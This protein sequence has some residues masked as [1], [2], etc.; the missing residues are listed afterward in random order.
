MILIVVDLVNGIMEFEG[1]FINSRG[2]R[3]FL[4]FCKYGMFLKC[5]FR[6]LDIKLG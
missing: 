3:K 2:Y 1:F 4:V 5:K 6:L